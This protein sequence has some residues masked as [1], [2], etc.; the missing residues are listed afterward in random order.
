MKKIL[1]VLCVLGAF[2]ST[3]ALSA[4]ATEIYIVRHAETVGNAT[5]KHTHHNDRTFS[6]RG[7]K[8][9]VE[10]TRDLDKLHF[11][12][13]IVSPKYRVLKTIFPYLKKHHLVAEIWPELAECCWQQKSSRLSSFRLYRGDAIVLDRKMKR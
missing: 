8:Q 9:V 12:H 2:V 7:K 11:D 4:P 1:M 13:I 5:H 10:L 3:A 6:A